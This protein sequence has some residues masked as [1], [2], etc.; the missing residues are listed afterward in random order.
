MDSS[1]VFGNDILFQLFVGCGGG[2]WL[3]I[4]AFPYHHN[5][6]HARNVSLQITAKF[7]MLIPYHNM[8]AG[9]PQCLGNDF[10]YRRTVEYF[11]LI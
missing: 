10:A 9:V 7:V 3:K 2:H 4:T 8:C 11:T 6:M 5:L 1:I